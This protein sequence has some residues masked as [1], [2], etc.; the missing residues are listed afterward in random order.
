MLVIFS[1]LIATI[2]IYE[3]L[4]SLLSLFSVKDTKL[5]NVFLALKRVKLGI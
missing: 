2:V 4:K 5:I 3:Y 1:S